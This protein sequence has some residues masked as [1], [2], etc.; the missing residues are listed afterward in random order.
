MT[1]SKPAAVT[2]AASKLFDIRILIG[3]LFV[4]YGVML[5][6]ASF[7]TTETEKSKASDLNINLWLGIGMLIVGLLFLLWFR[8]RPLIK[9][10]PNPTSA[11]GERPPG[12]ATPGRGIAGGKGTGTEGKKA[13]PARTG[14][15]TRGATSTSRGKRRR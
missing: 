9:V 5:I 13:G 2:S 3:S 12:T 1:E 7:F 15:K 10:D 4:L 8:L 11:P 14:G 6:V